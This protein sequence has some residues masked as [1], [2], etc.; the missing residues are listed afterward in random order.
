MPNILVRRMLEQIESEYAHVITLRTMSAT[1]G[2]QPAYLGRLFHQEVGSSVREHLTRVRLEHAAGL[3]RDGVK[4]EAVALSVG[5]R[6]KK[7]FYQRFKT[8]FGTTPV[9]YRTGSVDKRSGPE[10]RTAL[11]APGARSRV[12]VC[13]PEHHWFNEEEASPSEPVLSRLAS[14][15]RASSKAWRL[16]ARAQEIMLQHFTRLRVGILLTNDAGR[17]VAANRAAV[18]MTGYS[19]TELCGRSPS[20]LF[21]STPNAETR[22]VWQLLLFRSN[23]S[24]NSMIRTRAGDSIRVQVVTLKNVLWGRREMSAALEEAEPLLAGCDDLLP[25]G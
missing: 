11:E 4:I 23:Q 15:V 14:I 18:S 8:Q 24:P 3:I 7:N 25:V 2:R 6:S 17:Y 10:C 16:A 22:C 13:S 12:A 1:I 9:R 5:Y 20:D 19:T 21:V